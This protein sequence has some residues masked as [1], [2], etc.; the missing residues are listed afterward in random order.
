M[1]TKK[2]SF[3]QN[4]TTRKISLM[5]EKVLDAPDLK[6]D[7]YLNL[8]DWSYTGKLGIALN[9]KVYVYSHPDKISELCSLP[10]GYVCSLAFNN[11]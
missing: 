8:M 10:N 5:P 6:D 4:N 3:L 1:I 7:Y 9:N 11:Q 2:K